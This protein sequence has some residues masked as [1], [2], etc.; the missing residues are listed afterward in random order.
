MNKS[1]NNHAIDLSSH[2]FQSAHLLQALGIE[3]WYERGRLIE[4]KTPT[5]NARLSV[6]L[7]SPIDTL[8]AHKILQGMIRVLELQNHEWWIGW[9][10]PKFPSFSAFQFWNALHKMRPN[11]ALCLGGSLN[12]LP[13]PPALSPSIVTYTYHPEELA[14]NPALKKKSYHDLLT[15]KQNLQNSPMNDIKGAL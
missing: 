10:N 6:I 1:V 11:A 5:I 3:L 4:T 12:K 9:V 13:I 8:E 7:A 14:E 2:G 15:L